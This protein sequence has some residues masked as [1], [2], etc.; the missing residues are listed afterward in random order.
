MR[1]V[2]YGGKKNTYKANLH[3]HTDVS[4]GTFT[5]ETIKEI[6]K[7]KGYSIVAFSDHRD[8]RSQSHLNDEHFLAINSCEVNINQNTDE[9]PLR[10]IK[11]YHFN[12]YAMRTDIVHTPPLPNMRYDDICAINAYIRERA[13]EGFLVCYNHPYWSMQDCGDYGKLRGVFAIEIFNYGCETEGYYGYNPQAYDEMLRAG[14]RLHCISA[15]DNHNRFPPD[16]DG[17]DSFGGYTMINCDGLNYENVINALVTGDFYSSQGPE[18]H[19]I[20]IENNVLHVKCSEAK[21]IVVYTDG[22]KCHIKCGDAITEAAFTLGGMEKY[23]RVM[24]RDKD[25]SD[26]N[27]NAFWL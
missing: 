4:D 16:S 2:L 25:K 14:A 17:W 10:V 12:L 23:V 15:D 9:I 6:Y 13:E 26:A 19:G 7:Q 21:L 20:S 3:C 5:P 18:I 24:V 22:R 1:R 27:S 11:T 8:L